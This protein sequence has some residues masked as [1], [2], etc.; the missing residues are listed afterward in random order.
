MPQP[1]RHTLSRGALWSTLAREISATTVYSENVLQPMKWNRLLPLQEKRDV[2]S[3]IKPLPWVILENKTQAQNWQ[4]IS[5]TGQDFHVHDLHSCTVLSPKTITWSFD[6]SWFWD[7]YRTCTLHTVG[8]TRVQPCPLKH[9]QY[10]TFE[11][12]HYTQQSYMARKKQKKGGNLV[13]TWWLPR[14]RSPQR[15]LPR[16]PAP[17]GKLPQGRSH[18]V[19]RS[20]CDRSLWPQSVIKDCDQTHA[21]SL[22]NCSRSYMKMSICCNVWKFFSPWIKDYI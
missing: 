10:V 3:G 18:L 1:S 9:Q 17:P 14:R 4:Q 21:Q 2:P 20:Q 16:G 22:K 6:T 12:L 7:S 15:R 19:C 5:C 11:H 8:R 13:E